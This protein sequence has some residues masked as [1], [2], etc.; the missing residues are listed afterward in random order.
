[1][2]NAL[3]FVLSGVYLVVILW[4]SDFDGNDIL[5]LAV[6][7]RAFTILIVLGAVLTWVVDDRAFLSQR[8]A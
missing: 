3:T 8:L 6:A 5:V 1:M 4:S 7:A 2:V